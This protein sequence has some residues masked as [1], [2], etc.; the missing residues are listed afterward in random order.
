MHEEL[1]N[2][3]ELEE[4]YLIS[5]NGCKCQQF[6]NGEDCDNCN[7]HRQDWTLADDADIDAI[8][9]KLKEV[10]KWVDKSR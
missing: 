3:A 7:N 10:L 5:I 9:T 2:M 1:L 6:P 8:R 4:E